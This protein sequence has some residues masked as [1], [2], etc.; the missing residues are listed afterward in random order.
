MEPTTI[1]DIAC[2]FF[3][4][5]ANILEDFMRD[6]SLLFMIL[7]VDLIFLDIWSDFGAHI[8]PRNDFALSIIFPTVSCLPF[9]RLQKN[10]FI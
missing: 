4:W 8:F 1:V 3:K 2:L 7:V 10:K 9:L 6:Q 5:M